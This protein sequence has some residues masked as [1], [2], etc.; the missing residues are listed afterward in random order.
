MAGMFD[1]FALGDLSLP[2]RFVMA[3]LT[4]AR[5]GAG[6]VP[7]ELMAQ[8]Y[9]QRAEAGLLISEAT[10]VS[11]MSRPFDRA[12]GLYT[13]AQVEGWEQVTARVHDA[14]GRIFAQLWHGGR[15]G[16]MGLLDWRQ[17]VSPSGFNDDVD[18]LH[19][20]GLLDN[21]N[22]VRVNATPSRALS[23]EE[24]RATVQEY[25][26]AA[27]NARTAG[28]DGVEI[29]A[30]NGYLPHQFLSARVNR[31]TD[32]YGGSVANRARFLA[33]IVDA[34]SEVF[35]L[36]RVGV[37][38]SPYTSYNNAL[39]DQVEPMY[40]HVS[41]FFDSRK[42]AY[43][44]IADVNGWYGAPDMAKILEIVRPRFSGVLIANGGLTFD[45]ANALV[46]DRQVELVSFGRHFIANPDLVSRLKSGAA[47]NALQEQ[48]LYARGEAGYTDYP[49]LA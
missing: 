26:Q 43:V 31:R 1:E 23:T 49:R 46:G 28:F 40:A 32:E 15:V 39:D 22:Y 8:Y 18:S 7:N 30:A 45:T 2:N 29:H 38:I 47:L 20:W 42:V 24:V 13:Q 5:A 12:P 21:G 6:D 48:N 33:E 17:P 16:A 37:R 36:S 35:P 14:G 27:L 3:P 44:H 11:A 4:R 10:N 9:A 41:S 25:R 34:V 19:V